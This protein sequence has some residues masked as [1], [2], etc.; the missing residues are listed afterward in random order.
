MDNVGVGGRVWVRLEERIERASPVS[1]LMFRWGAI[2]VRMRAASL[3]DS[4]LISMAMKSEKEGERSKARRVRW[5][6]AP[7]PISMIVVGRFGKERK[8]AE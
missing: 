3:A 6:W 1:T 8:E 4:G 2:S 5:A 7:V